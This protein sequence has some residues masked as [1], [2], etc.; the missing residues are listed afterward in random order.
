[1]DERAS[2]ESLDDDPARAEIRA[3]LRAHPEVTLHEV[4]ATVMRDLPPEEPDFRP[5]V[6][7]AWAAAEGDVHKFWA[8]LERDHPK[9]A[10]SLTN[11]VLVPMIIEV[12][13]QERAPG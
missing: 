1:M 9:A 13:R 12:A 10:T 7:A 3:Y 11:T 5:V 8:T 2:A 6:A 4:V